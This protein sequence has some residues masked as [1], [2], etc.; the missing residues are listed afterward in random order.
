MTLLVN[1]RYP[2]RPFPTRI[3]R[4]IMREARREGTDKTRLSL[5]GRSNRQSKREGKAPPQTTLRQRHGKI[6]RNLPQANPSPRRQGRVGRI[7]E[8]LGGGFIRNPPL[9][10][11]M[12]MH[13][14][15]S[16]G[17]T[18]KMKTTG[19]AAQGNAGGEDVDL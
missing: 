17:G 7:I 12:A 2:A 4:R 9:A 6:D 18:K 3:H 8:A 16:N 15:R 1:L 11:G 13:P 10:N 14:N 5:A 19:I